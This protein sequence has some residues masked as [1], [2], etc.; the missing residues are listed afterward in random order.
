MMPKNSP[1]RCTILM[2]AAVTFKREQ[3]KNNLQEAPVWGRP[4]A[5]RRLSQRSF[6]NSRVLERSQSRV[7]LCEEDVG[8][9][10]VVR[11]VLLSLQSK[12][13]PCRASL[14]L[15]EQ[16]LSLQGK[17]SSCRAS[18]LLVGQ[19]LSLQPKSFPCRAS[20]QE[21]KT[22]WASRGPRSVRGSTQRMGSAFYWPMDMG[23]L[24]SPSLIS[25]FILFSCPLHPIWSVAFVQT[26]NWGDDQNKQS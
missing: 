14:I 23:L 20:L 9:F 18:L 15:A 5:L 8:A 4:N 19:V 22:W 6:Y 2:L 25:Y 26:V 17:S 11:P 24:G 3:N 1:V 16:V 12:P 21:S 10:I 7:P 13:S